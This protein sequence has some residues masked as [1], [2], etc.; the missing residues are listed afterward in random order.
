MIFKYLKLSFADK[1]RGIGCFPG[2]GNG[3]IISNDFSVSSP[4]GQDSFFCSDSCSSGVSTWSK[5]M[6][7]RCTRSSGLISGIGDSIDGLSENAIEEKNIV[8]DHTCS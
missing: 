3:S 6:I 4:N 2:G 7:L 1:S 8:G 5:P